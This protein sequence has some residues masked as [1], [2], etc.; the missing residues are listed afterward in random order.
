MKKTINYYVKMLFLIINILLPS[1]NELYSQEIPESILSEAYERMQYDLRASHILIKV[2]K[3]APPEDTLAAYKKIMTIR[4]RIIEGETFDAVAREASE[5]LSAIDHADPLSKKMVK[6]NGGDLGY[7]TVMNMVY[8]FE[9]AAYNTSVGQVSMPVRT[10]FGYHLITVTDRKPA[11][12]IVTV[13]HISVRIP[14][15]ANPEDMQKY[16]DKI[17]EAYS[18][19]NAGGKWEDVV[20]QYS[21]DKSS[22]AKGGQLPSF[23]VSRMVPDFI[24]AICN[25]KNRGDISEPVKT[26]FG[27]HIIKLIERKPVG[28]YQEEKSSLTQKMLKDSRFNKNIDTE[29]TEKDKTTLSVSDLNHKFT[30]TYKVYDSQSGSLKNVYPSAGNKFIEVSAKFSKANSGDFSLNG[31]NVNITYKLNGKDNSVKLSS[32]DSKNGTKGSTQKAGESSPTYYFDNP[33]TLIL[34]FEIPKNINCDISLRCD[35]VL[36]SII[37]RCE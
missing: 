8:P 3:N 23:G 7:F 31:G 14:T 15:D 34:D 26:I 10:G 28:T 16:K 12:G 22:V 37:G 4:N 13:A 20:T 24:I 19:L 6:G 17:N 27:W 32:I 11:M 25:L 35:D 33:S 9:T 2:D 18:K 29:K 30:E 1:S 36:K 5:D 21:D